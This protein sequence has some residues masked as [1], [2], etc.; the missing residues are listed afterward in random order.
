[1]PCSNII[2]ESEI[3][4]S[5][6]VRQLEGMF[7]IPPSKTSRQ[8]WNVDL[9][10]HEKEWNVGLI[11]GPSG[12]GKSVIKE[13][14]FKDH[15]SDEF[16]WD[17]SR[18][19]LDAFPKDLGIKDISAMLNSVGFSS[20]PSWLKPFQI[21][22]NGEKF[23]VTL[24]RALAESK[25]MCVVDEFTSVVD[26]VV[27]KCGSAAVAKT[28]RRY[29]KKFI[30]ISCHYDIE[31]WLQPDWIY[32]PHESEFLWRSLRPRPPIE[33]EIIKV[34]HKAW[35]LFKQY[36]YLTAAHNKAAQ[37]FVALY[38]GL[39]VAFFSY[40]QFVNNKLKRTK[41]GHRVV[42]MPDYQGV[43]IGMRL[44]E[45][46]ASCLRATGWDYIG[47]SAHPARNAYCAKSDN[48]LMIRRPSLSKRNAGKGTQA[49]N[50]GRML[51]TFRYTGSPE[52]RNAAQSMLG[53]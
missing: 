34:H 49:T 23:R 14:L 47:A 45:Y 27:A 13:E 21:L 12:C 50:L 15:I 4:K 20:P 5:P 39:P 6:G 25:D 7:D 40:L 36:H 16:K 24:A 29:G 22:S 42:V 38:G 8:E 32:K 1:M 10:I 48:W 52:E 28:V 37:C 17:R 35:G 31:E 26:R 3:V 46:I 11:V 30:A 43:G 19:I 41:R 18:S 33:L 9:P 51:T 53:N 2:R 44:E